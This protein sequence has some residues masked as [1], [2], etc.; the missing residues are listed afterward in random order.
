M[1][2][3]YFHNAKKPLDIRSRIIKAFEDGIF[4]LSQEI[5]HKEQAKEKEEEENEGTILDWIKVGNHV[6]KRIRE[7]V[8][9]Y[10]NK[11]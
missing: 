9:N 1:S 11:A 2:F 8:N 6:F 4:P 3:P 5:L 10:V 7:R